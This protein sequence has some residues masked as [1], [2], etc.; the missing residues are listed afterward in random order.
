MQ[1]TKYMLIL[2]FMYIN[3][4]D[5]FLNVLFYMSSLFSQTPQQEPTLMTVT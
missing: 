2:Y 4:L 3:D 1:Q 5:V